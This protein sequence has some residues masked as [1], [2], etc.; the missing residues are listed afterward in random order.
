[1]T[2][3][4][5]GDLLFLLNGFFD[6]WLLFGVSKFSGCGCKTKRLFLASAVG[7]CFGLLAVLPQFAV[8][9][10][11]FTVL[12]FPVLLLLITFGKTEKNK[13]LRLL[14]YYYLMAFAMNG[15]ASAGKNLLQGFGLEWEIF[16]VLVLPAVLVCFFA[17]AGTSFFKRFIA[18][19]SCFA[20]GTVN[21]GLSKTE[22]KVFFDTGNNLKEPVSGLPVMVAEYDIIMD[23]LPEELCEEYDKFKTETADTVRLWTLV[24]AKYADA[25]W[26][27]R[28]SLLSFR[29]VGKK[30][31]F[32][33]GFRADSLQIKGCEMPVVLA[34][35]DGKLGG[36]R[37][38]QA[39]VSPWIFENREVKSLKKGDVCG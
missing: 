33:L 11:Q 17:K 6:F 14:L 24:G 37:D 28:L 30:Q 4:V 22:I 18:K 15:V 10:N 8:F 13:F 16:P 29:S 2:Y 35:Y 3:V 20:L 12:L 9:Y 5:Y 7:G 38:F 36:R 32:L 1:M 25:D 39:I 27:G 34:L 26:F 23:I 19:D 21:F 31:G